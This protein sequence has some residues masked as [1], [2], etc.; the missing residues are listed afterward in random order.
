MVHSR[1]TK[2]NAAENMHG[3]NRPHIPRNEPRF[4]TQ[5]DTHTSRREV[6]DFPRMT[7]VCKN[8]S[9]SVDNYWWSDYHDLLKEISDC[10][11]NYWWSDDHDLLK[12]QSIYMIPTTMIQD[13][14]NI[15]YMQ[16]IEFCIWI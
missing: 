13:S 14:H 11:E 6:H 3:R 16:S 5:H 9:C 12:D 15:S 2:R 4:V 1:Y 10:V 7:Y 8:T